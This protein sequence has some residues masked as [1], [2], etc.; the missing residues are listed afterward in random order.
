[1]YVRLPYTVRYN[2]FL[3]KQTKLQHLAYSKFFRG[4]N[5]DFQFSR[6]KSPRVYHAWNRHWYSY[7]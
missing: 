6:D 7:S 1:M 3:H 2:F 5:G 4:D